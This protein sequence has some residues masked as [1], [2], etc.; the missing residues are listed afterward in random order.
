ML[1]DDLNRKVVFQDVDIGIVAHCFHQP[2]LDLRARIV[3][4]VQNS[5]L[6]MATLAVKIKSSF[7]VPIEIDAPMH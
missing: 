3:G 4:V 6:G 5:E 1:G 2:T 7:G